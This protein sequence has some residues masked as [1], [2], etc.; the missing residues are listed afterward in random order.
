[1]TAA[2]PIQTRLA[3]VL[4]LLAVAM[5]LA[6]CASSAPQ[7]TATAVYERARAEIESLRSTATVVRARMNT[8]LE[9]AQ[10]R[11]EQAEGAGEFLQFSLIGLGTEASF[12]VTTVSQIEGPPAPEVGTAPTASRQAAIHAITPVALSTVSPTAGATRLATTG[13]PQATATGARL[14]NIVMASGVDQYD[15]A[16]DV[17]PSIHAGFQR[18][19][20]GGRGA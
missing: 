7:L 2:Y 8:T 6:A 13:P 3:S 4:A 12:I 11:V 5:A 10:A 1:M 20:C 14:D 9:Y 15:C 16:I 17:K 19:L 18:D